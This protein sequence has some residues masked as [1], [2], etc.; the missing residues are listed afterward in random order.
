MWYCIDSYSERPV[1]AAIVNVLKAM[2]K[3]A[4]SIPITIVGTKVDKMLRMNVEPGDDAAA[5]ERVEDI[6]RREFAEHPDTKSLWPE[7]KSNFAFV[8]RG[9]SRPIHNRSTL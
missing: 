1:Q 2:S 9:K 4:P 3:E 5:V 8:S 7:L 6:F